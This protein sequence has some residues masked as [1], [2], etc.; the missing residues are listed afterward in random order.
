M[1]IELSLQ[2]NSL[3]FLHESLEQYIIADENGVHHPYRSDCN[4]KKKWKFAFINLVQATELLLK[5]IISNVSPILLKPNIDN[6]INDNKTINFTQCISRINSFSNVTLSSEDE[7]H[8][9][10]CTKLRNQFTHFNVEITSEEAKI[11]YSSLFALYKRLYEEFSKKS[12]SF[13]DINSNAIEE[14]LTFS[15]KCT[16][17]RGCEVLKEDIEGFKKDILEAQQHPC[18]IDKHGNIIKRIPFG[19]E[20]A[21]HK[22][23]E[24]SDHDSYYTPTIYLWDYCDDCGAAQGEYHLLNCDLELCP[25]C[26]GQALTCDCNLSWA[27]K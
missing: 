15:K 23:L 11:K 1:K 16:I 24:V 12:L 19:Q 22:G 5:E 13:Q 20:E 7:K 27:D 2:E 9:L 3:D 10:R 18:F 25:I 21:F 8:L 4:K 6:L 17:F 14:I 26:G